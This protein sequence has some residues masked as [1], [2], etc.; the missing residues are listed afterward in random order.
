MFGYVHISPDKLN[1]EEQQLYRACYC[2]LCHTLGRRYGVFARMILNYDLVFLAML[3]SDGEAPRCGRRRCLIHPIHPRCFCEETQA[4]DAAADVSVLLTWWQLRDGVADH[5]FWGGWKYR[6]LSLLLHR[7]YRK[8]KARQP[9]LDKRIQTNLDK[10]SALEREKCAIP[11]E[12][13]DTFALLLRDMAAL[14]PPGIKRRVLEEMLYHLG[15]WIYL[16]DALDD[17]KED[18]SIF[19]TEGDSAS[20]SITKSRDVTTQAVFSLRGKP[21]NCFGLT[22]KVVYE[23][24]EFN[25]LQA[26]LNIED[27]LDG[28][29]YNKV[30][31]ATDADVDGM[32]IRL[33]MI[34]FF[35]QFFP[36]L[37]K[38][39]HVYILQTPLFRVRNRKNKIGKQKLKELEEEAKA[40]KSD[41]I[42]RYCYSDEERVAA[43]EALGPDPEITRFKGLGEISPDEFKHF[44]GPD[45]RLEQVSL[46]KSD[47]VKELLE[48]YMGKNT[49][50]RQN[51]IINNLVI[52]ED[53]A[54][55]DET[56]ET[57]I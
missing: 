38:K 39:G 43:I 37:I 5:G 12:V 40:A 33:L 8:A 7:A 49:M 53:R 26:A 34:T 28:L 30:I 42:T 35:L 10:L 20:G 23:N 36:E 24:E 57:A 31:V 52:E 4:L 56:A 46:H 17:L 25:L 41:F 2:G 22:K 9:E 44:I 51:F 16:V 6:F 18:S 19:I 1:G 11:D 21:L 29:R 13:A 54:E 50:E 55:E 48:Y 45:I 3:L 14:S 47:Q 15:R 27:G 32:H